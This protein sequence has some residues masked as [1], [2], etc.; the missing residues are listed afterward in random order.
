MLRGCRSPWPNTRGSRSATDSR[1]S[2]SAH[3]RTTRFW[4]VSPNGSESGERQVSPASGCIV[5]A[6]KPPSARMLRRNPCAS[7]GSRGSGRILRNA[8]ALSRPPREPRDRSPRAATGPRERQ[9]APSTRAPRRR[10]RPRRTAAEL[11]ALPPTRSASPSRRRPPRAANN[12]SSRDRGTPRPAGARAPSART[13]TAPPHP[14]LRTR[15]STTCSPPVVSDPDV[16]DRP[17]N[18]T[19]SCAAGSPVTR[20]ATSATSASSATAAAASR[21]T[22][23]LDRADHPPTQVRLEPNL[24]PRTAP[25]ALRPGR[26]APPMHADVRVPGRRRALQRHDHP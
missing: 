16:R 11:A 24:H 15:P 10:A 22:P 25:A 21:C 7:Q 1:A 19:E 18:P 3:N 14:G 9:R 5:V 6:Q 12:T 2:R 23:H 13:T 20:R 17:R 8:P 4:V 26:A